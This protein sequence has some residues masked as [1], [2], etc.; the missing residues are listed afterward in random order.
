MY[1]SAAA[2]LMLVLGG[3]GSLYSDHSASAYRSMAGFTRENTP[4]VGPPVAA[5]TDVSA[6]P[7]W[8]MPNS[9]W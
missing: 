3:C 6:Q 8:G 1:L 2:A 5:A 9:G 7:I 4:R